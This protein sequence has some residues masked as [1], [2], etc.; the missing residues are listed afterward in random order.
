MNAPEKPAIT[1]PAPNVFKLA[2]GL[3]V[4]HHHNPALPLVAAEVVI[5]SGASANPVAQPGLA[6]FTATM[7]DEGT[8]SRSS[9]QIA[10]DLAQLGAAFSAASGNETSRMSLLSLRKNFAGALDIVADMV[11]NPAFPEAE[12]ERQRANRLGEL[13]QY[14]EDAG[15][16]GEIVAA[17][18]LYGEQHP[19]GYIEVG[20]EAAIK[21]T[22]RADLLAFW[23]RNYLPNNAAL[24]LSGD[25]TKE[26]AQAL[27]EASFGSWQAGEVV[28]PVLA[29]PATTAAN[30]I[31]VHKGDASQTALHAATGFKPATPVEEGIKRFVAW[32]REYHQV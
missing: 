28:R 11:R 23:Q 32:Y 4:L 6:G 7:L 19:F 5:R 20:T 16:V 3:T 18:A 22:T 27:A 30:A 21:A 10:D 14:H 13:T 29:A 26:E 25:L 17:S 31:L 1:L 8:H 2:N 15:A 24:V 12:V 9:L